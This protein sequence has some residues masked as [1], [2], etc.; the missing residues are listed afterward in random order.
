MHPSADFDCPPDAVRALR[1]AARTTILVLLWLSPPGMAALAARGGMGW[2]LVCLLGLAVAGAATLVQRLRPAGAGRR[3]RLGLALGTAASAGLWLGA[4]HASLPAALLVA[5]PF[6]ALVLVGTLG[7]A[8]ALLAALILLGLVC[9]MPLGA[10]A[11]A[12][13][14]LPVIQAGGLAVLAL[15]LL[16]AQRLW[17]RAARRRAAIEIQPPVKVQAR[18][19]VRVFSQPAQAAAAPGLMIQA[20]R[21]PDG[22]LRVA[23]AGHAMPGAGA[24]VRVWVS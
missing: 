23:M 17:R 4:G 12:G 24:G 13:A 15:M 21:A 1:G 19:T 16:V 7:D 5:L 11:G 8:R 22:T 9:L 3:G 2:E 6:L 14:A 18:P 20:E 10:Q